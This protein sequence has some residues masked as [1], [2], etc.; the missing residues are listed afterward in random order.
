M[1]TKYSIDLSRLKSAGVYLAEY[2]NTAQAPVA[3][4]D[5]L[6]L[7]V[8]FN[9]KG[10]FN[11]PVFL[12]SEAD[13]VK[14]LGDIDTKLERKGCFFNRMA[15]TLLTSSPILALNLLSVDESVEG[16]DQVNWAAMSV[17]AGDPNPEVRGTTNTG[18][19]VEFDT[20]G[21]PI[22]NVG[23]TPY[24]TL[25]DR[26]KFWIPS[27]DNL[28]A[29]AAKDLGTVDVTTFEHTNFL[30]F[31]NIGT[32]EISILVFKPENLIGFDVTCRDWY[33][34]EDAIPFGFMRPSDFIAD[35]FIQVLA[36]KGNWTDYK[37]LAVDP[38]WGEFFEP[39]GIRK[40][41]VNDFIGMDG[42]SLL[43]SWVGAI[44]PN[45]QDK[46]GNNQYIVPM[47]NDDSTVTGLLAAFNQDAAAI[48]RY[49]YNGE[50][51][52]N[53]PGQGC[54]YYDLDES[55]EMDSSLGESESN[56]RT[57][58]VD[59][60]GHEFAEGYE[61]EVPKT[62]TDASGNVVIEEDEEG[63]TI[64]T[65]E[66]RYGIKMLSYN[67]NVDSS[68]DLL[69]E[70]SSVE[71]LFNAGTDSDGNAPIES[72]VF[73]AFII[74]NRD[75]ADKI[76]KGDL[77]QNI[78][79]G[80]PI[81][82]C[83]YQL[84]PG[85]TRVTKKVFVP[86]TV[87]GALPEVDAAEAEATGKWYV[88]AEATGKFSYK[89]K[90]YNYSG[91][92]IYDAKFGTCG[93]YLYN[94]IDGIKISEG[95][96]IKQYAIGS[97][98][99]S[100]TLNFIP[101]RGL[102][103]GAR[104]MPGYDAEGNI[105]AEGGVEKIYKVLEDEG[106]SRGLCNP[107]M[108][109]FRYVVDS[110]GYGLNTMMGG[111]VYLSRLAKK[112]GKTTAILNLPSMR[113]FT[114]ST[115]P[116]FCD[117][118]VNGVD[119]KPAFDTKYIPLG[120]NDELYSSRGFSLPDE[121]NG[122]KFT[123]VFGPYLKYS[124]NG[125]TIMVPPAAD[126][127]N[128]L[129]RKFQGGD[130][131]MICANLNGILSNQNLNG[132]EYM[133]DNTDRDYL[134]PFGVNAIIS[135]RGNVMIYGNQTTYQT[136]KSDF[137]K[138]HVRENLNTLEIEVENVLHN[139]VFQYNNAITRAAVVTNITPILEAMLQSGAIEEYVIQCDAENNTE[140]IISQDILIVDISVVMAR[141]CEKILTRITLNRKKD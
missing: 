118:F 58:Y 52:N 27:D 75:E 50:E 86:V 33:G 90:V 17:A 56:H 13:R 82:A 104:H 72:N 61:V 105:D 97:P 119:I 71:Y 110:M 130:P 136:L 100:S 134:E 19:W 120:G 7:L 29:V 1:A 53:E 30:N 96:A 137:N 81:A 47:I 79:F 14:V 66:T 93:F 124:V 121:D 8:G 109:N 46:M 65:K 132:L 42:I 73:S 40:N 127:A 62:T 133:L 128:V 64:Y 39:S 106:I 131:Y 103:L 91:E 74:T 3:N 41:K 4:I 37:N 24:A 139:Y 76:A 95:V 117:T 9:K 28:M 111:K 68:L 57:F 5:S 54:W 48:L 35:Y 36:V 11:R 85:L 12:N 38:V 98:E 115:N 83:Q 129:V 112:K 6:R 116:Y 135:R 87:D 18:K 55:G 88:S 92:V 107:E 123:A 26:S 102:S 122:A 22:E 99:V 59:M 16:P 25:F 23:K 94:T 126:V 10:P 63:N 108:V 43:G 141:G 138:L 78:A 125:R 114:T 44:I 140:E 20:D 60:V 34:S 77:V 67:K 49:D 89:G 84:I 31:G 80:D 51:Y 101:M 69:V 113:Q 2:D 21:K 15:Q 70:A 45:F 32:E